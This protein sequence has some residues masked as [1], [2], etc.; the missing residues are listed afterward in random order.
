[1]S[2]ASVNKVVLVGNLGAD[3]ELRFTQGGGQVANVSL[4]TSESWTDKNGETKERA[5]WHRLVMWRR[6]A[7]IANQYLKKGSKIYA[8]GK[9]QTRSWQDQKGQRHYMTEVVVNN[10][11]MHLSAGNE[12][13]GIDMA[14]GK[15]SELAA[16]AAGSPE[17]EDGLPF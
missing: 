13:V 2:R 1:M 10:L 9:L 14:Y 4:A 12:P 11:E 5:E 6:L 8:E 16:V 15:G 3:P 7:E 17:P